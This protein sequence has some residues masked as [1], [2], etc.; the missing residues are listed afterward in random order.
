MLDKY[1]C[2]FRQS[3]MKVQAA[4]CPYLS[5]QCPKRADKTAKRSLP[6]ANILHFVPNRRHE[7]TLLAPR[8]R[9]LHWHNNFSHA[10]EAHASKPTLKTP[11]QFKP[12]F[13]HKNTW[14]PVIISVRVI[15]F[16]KIFRVH[17][18]VAI[19]IWDCAL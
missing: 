15:I 8:E 14:R 18:S 1:R 12:R 6:R 4:N 10:V 9:C 2:L 5:K 7:H 19:Q 17:L 16:E 13:W 3:R 11:A